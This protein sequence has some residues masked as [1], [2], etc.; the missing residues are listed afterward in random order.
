MRIQ[1][2]GQITGLLKSEAEANFDKYAKIL[3]GYGYEVWNPME[4]IPYETPWDDAMKICLAEL[5]KN[6]AIFKLDNWIHSKG[7]KKEFIKAHAIGK[8]IY[9]TADLQY[10]MR[11][12]HIE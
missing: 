9:T 10:L 12:A 4:E 11:T 1:L 7:A 6:D 5:E 3:R 2:V 8:Y